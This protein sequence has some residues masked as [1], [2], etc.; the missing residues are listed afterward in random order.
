MNSDLIP[1]FMNT[2]SGILKLIQPEAEGMVPVM[3]KKAF[4]KDLIFFGGF[5]IQVLFQNGH[6]GRWIKTMAELISG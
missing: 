2:G 5:C 6:P 4:G 1:D 3:V